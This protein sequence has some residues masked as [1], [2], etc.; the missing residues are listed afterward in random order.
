MEELKTRFERTKLNA[1]KLFERERGRGRGM[2]RGRALDAHTNII[3][4][5]KCMWYI[6]DDVMLLQL[7]NVCTVFLYVYCLIFSVLICSMI[8]ISAQ[9]YLLHHLDH[10]CS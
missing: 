7:V 2:G 9:E 1:H 6:H 10:M 4:I 8:V 5:L 3:K